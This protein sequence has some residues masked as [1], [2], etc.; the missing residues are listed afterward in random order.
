VVW[1]LHVGDIVEMRIDLENRNDPVLISGVV[2][3]SGKV[4]DCICSL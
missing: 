4:F 2:V 1:G 3:Q